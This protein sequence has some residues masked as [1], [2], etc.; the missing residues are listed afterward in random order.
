MK[1][2]FYVACLFFIGIIFSCE[3][4]KIEEKLVVTSNIDEV[5]KNSGGAINVTPSDNSTID[6]YSEFT[7][8]VD[9][10]YIDYRKTKKQKGDEFAVLV[11]TVDCRVDINKITIKDK[12]SKEIPIEVI[13][14]SVKND[15]K[16]RF[17]YKIK[18]KAFFALGS[19]ITIHID[20]DCIVY[21]RKYNSYGKYSGVQKNINFKTKQ[22]EHLTDDMV[23]CVYPLPKQYNYMQKEYPFGFIKLRYKAAWIKNNNTY[24]ELT[25]V[26]TKEVLKIPMEY[27]DELIILKYK[28]PKLS[29]NNIYKL[30]FKQ[31]KNGEIKQ[32]YQSSYFKTSKFNKFSD[33]I[34]D[35]LD[36]ER[37]AVLWSLG[38]CY[39][40]MTV[41]NY[42][43]AHGEILD[44]YEQVQPTYINHAYPFGK[45]SYPKVVT[46]E[47]DTTK[48]DLNKYGYDD[49]RALGY[50]MKR[51]YKYVGYKP[52]KDFIYFFNWNSSKTYAD[53][54]LSDSE[55]ANAKVNDYVITNYSL[56]S[57]IAVTFLRDVSYFKGKAINDDRRGKD[58]RVDRIVDIDACRLPYKEIYYYNL[59]YI[60]PGINKVTFVGKY[61]F[62][63][64]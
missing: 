37:N 60:I 52:I 63:C 47:I 19:N 28:M 56:K 34:G 32:L 1:K 22:F 6:L 51:E 23:T 13:S 10:N 9:S 30:D 27:D 58:Q 55:I 12:N 64:K 59:K 57:H 39:L 62:T 15:K 43:V 53:I 38:A 42:T 48:V 35:I 41:S 11:D 24:V 17:K 7:I 61:K 5:I 21:F 29:N 4:E 31:E 36:G 44:F 49:A 20:Y 26:A 25:N 54:L 16:I 45:L 46:A 3:K 40:S 33:K 18:P 8:T 2:E 50:K 14:L